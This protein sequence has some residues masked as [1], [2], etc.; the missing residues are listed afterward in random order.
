MSEQLC[1][2]AD[3]LCQIAD[4]L[5]PPAV[6]DLSARAETLRDDATLALPQ[7]LQD[8]RLQL[9]NSAFALL[10][11]HRQVLEVGIRI[12]EQTQHGALARHAKA[13]AELLHARAT[14]LGLQAKLHTFSHAPPVEFVAALK[15]FRKAQGS[16][17]K[18]LKDREQLARRE[19]ELYE[20]AGEKGMRDLAKRKMHLAG[21]IERIEE[22][23][24][25]LERGE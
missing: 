17:E 7:D 13:S 6:Q 19:L 14:L 23:I 3:Y 4:P 12:L 24:G 10:A 11:T 1:T 18:A 15:E 20:R 16:G 22:E 9:T 8:A 21:E 2:V 5:K 25:K